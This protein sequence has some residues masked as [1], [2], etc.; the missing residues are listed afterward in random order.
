MWLRTTRF[1]VRPLAGAP[2]DYQGGDWMI[3][4][5]FLLAGHRAGAEDVAQQ[6]RNLWPHVKVKVTT[7]P[8]ET[9][10]SYLTKVKDTTVVVIRGY[11]VKNPLPIAAQIRE[12]GIRAI[13]VNPPTAFGLRDAMMGIVPVLDG[14]GRKQCIDEARA[15]SDALQELAS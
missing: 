9:L 3:R 11:Y 14:Y 5:I 6:L 4:K 2:A 1:Q 10:V 15:I 12:Q 13:Y 8:D 7:G